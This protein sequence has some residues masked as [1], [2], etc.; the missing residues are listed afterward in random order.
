MSANDSTVPCGANNARTDSSVAE[1]GRL[2][3]NNLV[4][5]ELS[6]QNRTIWQY[7]AASRFGMLLRW[8]ALAE[9]LAF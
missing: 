8:Q 6:L 7:E 4:T 2:P 1:K 5:R 9:I 3:T